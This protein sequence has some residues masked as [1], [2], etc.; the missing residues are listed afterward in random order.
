MIKLWCIVNVTLHL[1]RR[2]SFLTLHGASLTSA[3]ELLGAPPLSLYACREGVY[4]TH[5]QKTDELKE[6]S[7]P[8]Q[9]K[10]DRD[11][12][13]EAK[14]TA[15]RFVVPKGGR[16]KTSE[17]RNLR[18]ADAGLKS[19]TP[20]PDPSWTNKTLATEVPR[21]RPCKVEKEA[22][23]KLDLI[24]SSC[25]LGLKDA[26]GTDD[27]DTGW[28]LLGQVLNTI[29][30]LDPTDLEVRSKSVLATLRGIGPKDELEGLLAVQMV[31]VHHV[32]MAF[33]GLASPANHAVEA[34][35]RYLSRAI[36]L[37][38]TFTAQM[39]ALNR[40]RGNVSQQMVVGNVNVTEGGQAI[41]GP[42]SHRDPRK[43]STGNDEEKVG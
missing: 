35:D 26:F 40:H 21:P 38:R 15:S 4:K 1:A 30:N 2:F 24:N 3:L 43:V 22:E 33:L 9:R 39:E 20:H 16:N 7:M 25:F 18:D 42:V 8:A 32:A 29:P 6:G 27:E 19:T 34:S 37:L 41:V 13:A 28:L 10:D 11:C 17:K 14:D 23:A 31:G 36:K 5:V 12:A